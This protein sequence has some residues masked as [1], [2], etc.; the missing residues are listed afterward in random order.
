MKPICLIEGCGKISYARGNC[1]MH[2]IYINKRKKLGEFSD[3]QLM[4]WGMILP[5][6]TGRQTQLIDLLDKM[7]A[8]RK[9]D[10]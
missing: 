3:E 4:E 1:R 6:R 10:K 7:L 5:K 9:H 8:K 2:S